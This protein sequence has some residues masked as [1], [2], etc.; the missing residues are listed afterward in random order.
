MDHPR[1]LIID[2]DANLRRT[3]SDILKLKGYE[4]LAAEDGE[5]GLA[6]L[7][8]QGADLAL[9]DLG[10]PGMCG[11]EVLAGIKAD[12]P[13]TGAIVLTGQATIDSAVAATNRGAFSYL[14]KPYQ[15]DQLMNH[16][17][18]ALEKQL[19]EQEIAEH[20]AELERMNAELKTLHEVSE[21]I[22]R[23]LDM[24]ELVKEILQVLTRTRIFPFEV[25]GGIFLA[26]GAKLR[27]ASFVSLS[28]TVLAPC[29][30]IGPEQCLCGRALATGNV[31]IVAS[32][33]GSQ[34]ACHPETVG[35]GRIIVPLKA[36]DTVVGL[37]SLYTEPGIELNDSLMPL[38]CSL[39]SLVGIAIN[40]AR[41][42]EET[43]SAS[44]RDPLTGLANRRF[45][46]LQLEKVFELARRH[47]EHQSII[48]LDIDH[49]KSYNDSYGHLGGDQLL[50]CL[51][52]I[53][54]AQ[55]RK[56]DYVFRYGGEEFLVLLPGTELPM[57]RDAAERLRAA[58]EREAGVTIS[59]GVAAYQE[60]MPDKEALV[61]AADAALYRAKQAGR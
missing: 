54:T 27:L 39:G 33:S 48:M 8:E 18:R 15:I 61:K 12:F 6:L 42:Y 20:H 7:R 38:F 2:D 41:L 47:G 52:Q 1:I 23:T 49:F 34:L 11:L 43:K 16:I 55:M 58:V 59:L 40:N 25:R 36:V 29:Q 9:I 35:Y 21:A 44:L 17:R 53:L 51:A 24:D 32:D 31:I 46:E 37:I 28:E 19:A 60:G 13:L 45:L 3:L 4:T 57:A 10:L 56:S 22:S 30:E 14:V 50:V 5:K 26:E